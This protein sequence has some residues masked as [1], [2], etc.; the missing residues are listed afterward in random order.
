[1][2]IILP[3]LAVSHYH[4]HPTTVPV[5]RT[6]KR[7]VRGSQGQQN[8]Q[9]RWWLGHQLP[10]YLLVKKHVMLCYVMLCDR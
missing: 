6:V 2:S 9:C 1:M 4:R 5:H 7:F 8:G 3:V 10:D